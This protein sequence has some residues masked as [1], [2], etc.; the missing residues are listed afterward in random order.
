[1]LRRSRLRGS[2]AAISPVKS[3]HWRSR[4]RQSFCGR[5]DDIFHPPNHP[6]DL[7][8]SYTIGQS[9]APA[10][11]WPNELASKLRKAGIDL[12]DPV[13]IARTGWTTADLLLAM[14]AANLT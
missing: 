3:L 10:D 8:D 13:L 5:C 4:K 2:S 6:A 7:G 1:M 14:D 9:V 11:R 12:S